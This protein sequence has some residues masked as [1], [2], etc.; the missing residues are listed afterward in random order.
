MRQTLSVTA[1]KMIVGTGLWSTLQL[2][3]AVAAVILPV[4]TPPLGNAQAVVAGHVLVRAGVCDS[5][6]CHVLVRLNSP[7]IHGERL[8]KLEI[9]ISHHKLVSATKSR[10]Y[11]IIYLQVPNVSLGLKTC[12]MAV[13]FC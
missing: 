10:S 7:Y 9:K 5:G 13:F 2:V 11:Y 8:C 1:D 12:F 4:A 3:G 6:A